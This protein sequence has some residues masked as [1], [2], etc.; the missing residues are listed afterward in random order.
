ML[1][2]TS[3]EL[4]SMNGVIEKPALFPSLQG[5]SV[6]ISGGGSGIG[7]SLVEHFCS[8]GA[9]VCFVDIADEASNT[10]VERIRKNGHTVPHFIKCDIRDIDALRRAVTEAG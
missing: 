7:E 1:Q 10:V 3:L 4:N 9:R 8:Q 2:A 5:R 6:F